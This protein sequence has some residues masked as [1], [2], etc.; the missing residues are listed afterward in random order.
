MGNYVPVFAYEFNDPSPPQWFLPPDYVSGM[1]YGAYHASEVQYIFNLRPALPNPPALDPDQEEL[2][3]NMVH[4][5]GHFARFGNPNSSFTPLW[6]QYNPGVD[7]FRSLNTSG[8]TTELG[9]AT[10]HKCGL[11]TPGI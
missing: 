10:D 2:S 5:W 4:Y 1:P 11:W 8:P 9:F 3:E 7:E 6:P